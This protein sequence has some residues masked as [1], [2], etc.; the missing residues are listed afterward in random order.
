MD[1]DVSDVCKKGQ[2]LQELNLRACRRLTDGCLKPIGALL[3]NQHKKGIPPLTSLDLGG[4][5]RLTA[6]GVAAILP[7]CSSL[8]RLDLRGCK[9]LTPHTETLIHKYCPQMQDLVFPKLDP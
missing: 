4:C 5:G 8:T 3:R 7:S 1:M 6:D 9:Q 2:N